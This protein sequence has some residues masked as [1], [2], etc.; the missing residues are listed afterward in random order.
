MSTGGFRAIERVKG[1]SHNRYLLG[2]TTSEN[3]MDTPKESVPVVA[4][5]DELETFVP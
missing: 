2:Q 5:P 3:L 1:G 4:E